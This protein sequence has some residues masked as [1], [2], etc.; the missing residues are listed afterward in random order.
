MPS[1]TPV[2]SLSWGPRAAHPPMGYTQ[3]LPLGGPRLT[4]ELRADIFSSL[5]AHS[6]KAIFQAALLI[7]RLLLF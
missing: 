5:P 1:P 6:F 2:G 4:N 7:T 3:D